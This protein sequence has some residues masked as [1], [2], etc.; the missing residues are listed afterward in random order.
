[1]TDREV[2]DVLHAAPRG[3]KRRVF[4]SWAA[5]GL[6]IAL[7]SLAP[8]LWSSDGSWSMTLLRS[9]SWVVLGLV[10]GWGLLRRGIAVSGGRMRRGLPG[11]RV[12]GTELTDRRRGDASSPAIRARAPG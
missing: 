10:C 7:L 11:P 2:I 12:A 8:G 4:W 9:S 5:A 3:R 6:A 1:M